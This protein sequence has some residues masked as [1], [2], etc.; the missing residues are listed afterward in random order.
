MTRKTG[1]SRE[2]WRGW[3]ERRYDIIHKA[4]DKWKMEKQKGK[5][6]SRGWLGRK[7]RVT[8]AAGC[9]CW[10]VVQVIITIMLSYF[11]MPLWHSDVVLG[12]RLFVYSTEEYPVIQLQAA[13]L[14][15]LKSSDKK[16][17]IRFF[18]FAFT[19]FL[20]HIVSHFTFSVPSILL[21]LMSKSSL[22]VSSSSL[23]PRDDSGPHHLWHLSFF[24]VLCLPSSLKKWFFLFWLWFFSNI[25]KFK[26]WG[27]L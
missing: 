5:W 13:C 26:I 8:D 17:N 3:E 12:L 1:D 23:L 22:S 25:A 27:G 20:F 6:E 11:T 9:C 4:R 19:L 7:K 15:L 16:E 21:T 18:F 14:L 2:G 10:H 24:L